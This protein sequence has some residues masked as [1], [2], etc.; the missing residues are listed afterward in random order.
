MT[1]VRD[2]RE[3]K[4]EDLLTR[5][6]GGESVVLEF[7]EGGTAVTTGGTTLRDALA[8]MEHR[9]KLVCVEESPTKVLL[10]REFVT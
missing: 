7:T 9:R 8:E 3:E 5:I 2:E 1:L 4:V 6:D 10:W